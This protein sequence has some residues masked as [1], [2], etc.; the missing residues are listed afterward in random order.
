MNYDFINFIMN[1]ILDNQSE[2]PFTFLIQ[3]VSEPA[4]EP[5]FSRFGSVEEF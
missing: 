4:G 2:E 1:K 3:P 5:V